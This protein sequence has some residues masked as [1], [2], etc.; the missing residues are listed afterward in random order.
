MFRPPWGY[1]TRALGAVVGDRGL[2]GGRMPVVGWSVSGEGVRG[3]GAEDYARRVV[4][5]IGGH[6]IVQMQ[7]GVGPG[8]R[9][10]VE[11]VIGALPGIL[12][13]IGEKKLKV[14][15]LVEALV[16]GGEDLRA[17]AEKRRARAEGS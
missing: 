7:D 11:M 16:A 17:A 10:D 4:K 1:K 5:R 6:D 2:W 8:A 3:R 14:V 9:G 12:R 13:G 15:G